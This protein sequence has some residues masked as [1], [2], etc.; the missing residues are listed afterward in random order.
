MDIWRAIVILPLFFGPIYAQELSDLD[1]FRLRRL[2]IVSET[3]PEAERRETI[4]KLQ[5]IDTAGMELQERV[6]QALR[7]FG[8]YLAE[9]DSPQVFSVRQDQNGRSADASVRVE[10]G[11]RYT[12]G[13]IQFE[14][15]HVFPAEE[16]RR[17]FHCSDGEHFNATE[18]GRG[19]ERLK[20]LY[21]SKGY[22][23]FGA[24]PKPIIDSSA[25]VVGLT[26]DM[27]EGRPVRFGALRLD[28]VEPMA[29]A[30]KELLASWKEMQGKLY[31]PKLLRDWLATNTSAWPKDAAEQV[32]TDYF[33]SRDDPVTFNVL[34]H[35]QQ[36]DR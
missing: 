16:M 6:R 17:Q 20:D 23:N 12:L 24:I 28:G 31:N 35:F 26:I 14:G 33:A 27:D 19:L 1:S 15:G 25:H 4:E 3:L 13:K 8:Y 5:G 10:P 34:L 21:A 32:N 7:D 9:V 18:I 11:A 29:G 30:G 22:A 36:R 2:T